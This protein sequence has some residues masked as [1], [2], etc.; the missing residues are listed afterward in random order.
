MSTPALRFADLFAGVGGFHAALRY[1]PL[2]RGECVY[3]SE[4]DTACNDVYEVN[5]GARPDGDIWLVA[6]SNPGLIP[7]HDM[8]CAGFPWTANPDPAWV[9]PGYQCAEVQ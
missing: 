9:P 3:A 8:L 7:D 5:Y 2:L 4:I 6:R 1:S